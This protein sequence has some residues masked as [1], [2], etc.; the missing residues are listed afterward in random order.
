MTETTY[1]RQFIDGLADTVTNHALEKVL[2]DNF[3]LV[4]VPSYT[5]EEL[6]YADALAKTYA[7]SDKV[8]GFGAENSILLA[9]QVRQMQADSGHAMNDFLLPLYQGDVFRPG[10]TDVGDVSWQ[11]PTAQIHVAAWPNGS[12]GHSWQ[13]VSCGRTEIG[14]KAVSCAGKVLALT[15]IDLLTRPELLEQAKEEFQIRA[16]EGYTCPIPADAVPVIPD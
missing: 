13:N 11:C 12:P 6:D 10:S 9:Q 3:Q 1:E 15:A 14:R 4:G 16:A 5:K 8:P 2:F 7:G